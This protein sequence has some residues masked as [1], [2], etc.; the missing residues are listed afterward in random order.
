MHPCISADNL[1]QISEV[2][3]CGPHERLASFHIEHPH[4]AYM[5]S[6]VAVPNEISQYGLIER[7][8]E[9]AGGVKRPR[10]RGDQV[11]RSDHVAEAQRWE[12]DLAESS[13]VDPPPVGVHSLERADRVAPEPV[14]AII[15]IFNDPGTCPRRPIK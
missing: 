6:E 13:G 15:V 2:S 12:H 10:I 7:R 3:V 8:R 9:Y 14:L 11:F 4:P 1:E 5:A